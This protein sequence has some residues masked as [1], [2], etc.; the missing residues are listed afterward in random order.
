MCPP[1]C[2]PLPQGLLPLGATEDSQVQWTLLVPAFFMTLMLLAVDDVAT[3]LENP[4]PL[5]PIQVLLEGG[6]MDMHA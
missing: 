4:W 2:V 1:A 5:L 3:Q 6:V